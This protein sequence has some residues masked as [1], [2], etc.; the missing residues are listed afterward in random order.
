[1]KFSATGRVALG[2]TGA[3]TL[4]L[5]AGCSS[6]ASTGGDGSSAAPTKPSSMQ[7]ITVAINPSAQFASLYYGIEQGIFE[8]HNLKLKIVPQPDIA[9]TVAGLASGTYD[10]GQTTP[11]HVVA[12]AANG[13]QIQEV[14]AVEGRLGDNDQGTTIVASK[15]S[16]VTDVKDLAGKK[17][18]TVGLTSNNTYAT[19]ALVDKAGGN[20]KSIK[21]VQ[22]PF[23][24][25]V[26]ALQNGDVDVAIMQS[27]FIEQAVADGGTKIG[28]P[29]F[30]YGDKA[31]TVFD[32]SASY[33]SKHPDV[34]KAFSDSMIQSIQ[35]ANAN[36]TAASDSLIDGLKY[37]KEQAEGAK[38]NQGGNPCLN[39]G[40]LQTANK[41]LMDYGGQKQ[42]VDVNKL[43]WPE[44]LKYP[45]S[46]CT[47]TASK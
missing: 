3:A 14:S 21:Y 36:E 12:A 46:V 31:T 15:A 18:A 43:I 32:A 1:M 25:M 27:P 34:V 24:Q 9:Q 39:I 10:F 5:L 23:G 4:A 37:T 35:A 13:I 26:A 30:L 29:N 7:T 16:G 17:V 8:K 28:Y 2:V 42:K 11:I 45:A 6:P 20:W 33:I 40:G 22:L 38:R 19:D 41:L 44:A 47:P